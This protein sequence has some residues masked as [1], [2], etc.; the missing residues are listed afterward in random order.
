MIWT[1]YFSLLSPPT[2]WILMLLIHRVIFQR[3]WPRY[4]P[5][6]QLLSSYADITLLYHDFAVYFDVSMWIFGFVF[7]LHWVFIAVQAFS[8]AAVSRGDSSLQCSGFSLPWL[9]L[10]QSKGSRHG[11]S[12]IEAHRLSCSLGVLIRV[13]LLIIKNTFFRNERICTGYPK[14]WDS[15]YNDAKE[16][17]LRLNN[18]LEEWSIE[19]GKG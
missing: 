8:L 17:D 6:G 11:N 15:A 5:I 9:L 14:I 2:K 19:R 18:Y 16:G 10:L 13:S 4:S 1:P 12:V 7:W 3:T